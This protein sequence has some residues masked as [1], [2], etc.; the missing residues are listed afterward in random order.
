[1]RYFISF[2]FVLVFGSHCFAQNEKLNLS[3]IINSI[4]SSES[5]SWENEPDKIYFCMSY[6]QKNEMDKL[7]EI[8]VFDSFNSKRFQIL[9]GNDKK[10]IL[11]KLKKVEHGYIIYSKIVHYESNEL[12]LRIDI[13]K[14]DYALFKKMQFRVSS[15]DSS[16]DMH[17]TLKDGKWILAKMIC[18]GF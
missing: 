4:L 9:Y 16:W 12:T 15:I 1:M 18:N 5:C 7:E 11:K 6:P 13:P 8:I 14:T 2:F 17:Y 3:T 10:K